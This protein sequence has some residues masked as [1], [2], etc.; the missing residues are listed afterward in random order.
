MVYSYDELVGGLGRAVDY[1]A[2]RHLVGDVLGHQTATLAISGEEFSLYDVAMNGVSFHAPDGDNR[3]AIGKTFDVKVLLHDKPVYEGT[4][5]VAR[6]ELFAKGVRVGAQLLTGFLDLPEMRRHDQEQALRRDLNCGAKQLEKRVPLAYREVIASA[7]HFI[8]FYRSLLDE[9]E[10]RYADLGESGRRAIDVLAERALEQLRPRWA[11]LTRKAAETIEPHLDDR[12][13][14]RAAKR[15]T[16]TML[17][18]SLL[19]SPL[20]NRAYCKPL[21]YPGD[22]Q[23][24]VYVYKNALEGPNCFSRIF[25]KY[26]CDEPLAAGVR[27][28]KDLIKQL[29][30]DET[31]RIAQSEQNDRM[32]RVTSLASGPAREVVEF[33]DERTTWPINIHWT[34]IDQEERALSLAYH[35]V[36]RKIA[37]R[38]APCTLRCMYMSFLQFIKD[39]SSVLANEPQDFIY[40][41]GLFD[42]L[43][44]RSAKKLIRV[45]FENLVPGGVIAVGNALRP[46]LHFWTPEFLLDWTLIYRSEEEMHE[47]A[48]DVADRTESIQVVPEASNAYYFLLI[49]KR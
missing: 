21:G 44:K 14:I 32:V 45:L 34:L 7:A 31:E 23:T 30:V 11:E 48:A 29:T 26:I 43:G 6:T 15:Y 12:D 20:I 10:A 8:Q 2:E 16:N 27:T 33:V 3:W 4:A 47:L 1:R 41:A 24:M 49:R 35:D 28:R 18:E 5:R 17:T 42:Y 25:H 36:Y 38:Q 13:V 40:A 39:P 46:A 37:D 19:E 22:F 9:H